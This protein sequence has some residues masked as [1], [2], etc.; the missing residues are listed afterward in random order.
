M[1]TVRGRKRIPGTGVGGGGQVKGDLTNHLWT[2][3]RYR[4]HHHHPTSVLLA[5]LDFRQCRIYTHTHTQTG[6]HTHTN[7]HIHAHTHTEIDKWM[8]GRSI[9]SE[10]LLVL[11]MNEKKKKMKKKKKRN[12]KRE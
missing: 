3:L 1:S 2:Q 5:L 4:F 6:S 9:G 10:K 12:V 8:D 7:D 11:K